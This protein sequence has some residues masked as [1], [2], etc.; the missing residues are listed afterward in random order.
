MGSALLVR[1][2][3]LVTLSLCLLLGASLGG[4]FYGGESEPTKKAD[5]QLFFLVLILEGEMGPNTN[6][7]IRQK[8]Q[9]RVSEHSC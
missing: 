8:S 2:E 1:W 6:A 4:N 9:K 5:W 3:D 7:L